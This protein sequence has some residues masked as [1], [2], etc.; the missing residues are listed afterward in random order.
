MAAAGVW[1]SVCDSAAQGCCPLPPV[2]LPLILASPA[3]LQTTSQDDQTQR[4]AAIGW[5]DVLRPWDPREV[6]QVS[7]GS[8]SGG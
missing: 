6:G 7:P 3:A 8:E 2:E 5:L 4:A 1:H